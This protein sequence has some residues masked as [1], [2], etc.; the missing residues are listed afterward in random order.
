MHMPDDYLERVYS[1][2]LGKLIGVYLGRPFEGWSYDEVMERLG[3]ITYYVHEKLAMPLVVTDDDVSGT[4]TFIRALEDYRCRADLS[5]QEIGQAWLNYV[6]EGRSIFWWGGNGTS[7]EHTAW[8]NL[9]KGI[10][11]PASGAIATNGQGVAEQ[12]GA[13]I[14]IDGWAMVAPGQP[15]LAA[16]LA[17]Q[18]GKVSHDGESVYAA[19]LWAAMEAQAFFTSDIN[20]LLD[21]GLSVIPPDCLIARLIRDIRRWRAENADWRATRRLIEEHYGYDKYPGICHVIPNH[22]LMVMSVLY[23]P[24]DFSQAQMIINTSGWDT[25]CNA[26]NVG[27]LMGLMLGL[28]G[29]D[30]GV[31]WRTPIADRMLIS[32]ADGGNSIHDAVRMA[33]YIANLGYKLQNLPPLAAPKEGAPFHFSLPSSLQGFRPQQGADCHKSVELAN[34]LTDGRRML[35]ISYKALERGYY[36]AATTPTFSPKEVLNMRSYEL[37][38]TPLI[39]PGQRLRARVLAPADNMGAMTVCLRIRP[40]NGADELDNIDSPPLT[41][42]AGEEAV[43]Q[44]V[45]PEMDSQPIA[46][47]GLAIKGAEK[48]ADGRLLVDYVGWEGTPNLT[49]RRPQQGGTFWQRAWV[50]NLSS[51]ATFFSSSFHLSQSIGEG[52][53]AYGTREWRDYRVKTEITLQMGQYGGVALRVQG[54]R[55][56]YAVRVTK[57][58]SIEIVRVRDETVTLLAEADFAFAFDTPINF[59]VCIC[60]SKISATVGGVMLEAIDENEEALTCGGIGLIICEGTLCADYVTIS[61]P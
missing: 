39:A 26:G 8:L 14:F 15:K 6:I 25:D 16:R 44:W 49:L 28:A 11:A 22:A 60:G 9:N 21:V 12:I 7:T 33:Y 2:I 30:A 20:Q 48:Q 27:C 19:M 37:M 53:I 34:V 35:E 38:A 29:L 56:Y 13:Q 45:V 46:E 18:A 36:A 59:E 55:R 32:S 1:G 40:Y 5:S 3:E 50:N 17:E 47:I 52:F 10:A 24:D 58:G 51:F 42:K 4:F 57:A 43:L 23:A 41:L 61:P 31:D 54:R